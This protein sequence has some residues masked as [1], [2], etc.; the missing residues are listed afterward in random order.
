MIFT[1]NE[2]KSVL[3]QLFPELFSVERWCFLR[4]V[5]E[6]LL[7]PVSLVN[8]VL[9][10]SRFFCWNSLM[11][12]TTLKA[13]QSIQLSPNYLT[14]EAL[15]LEYLFTYYLHETVGEQLY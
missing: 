14:S 10:E 1:G 9:K 4:D 13:R 7:V 5:R 12:I 11:Y 6:G 2:T 8:G 3:E 15:F